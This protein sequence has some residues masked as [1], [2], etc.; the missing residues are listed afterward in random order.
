MLALPPNPP[1]QSDR[2]ARKIDAILAVCGGA[3]AAVDGQSVA[4]VQLCYPDALDSVSLS[5]E[6]LK[7]HLLL[8]EVCYG[9]KS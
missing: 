7:S 6:V 3:L 4:A 8:Q 1:F 9:Q 2:F 5:R